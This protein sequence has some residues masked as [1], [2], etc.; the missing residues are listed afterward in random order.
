MV[1][2]LTKRLLCSLPAS[3][4]DLRAMRELLLGDNYLLVSSSGFS[5]PGCT[6]KRSLLRPLQLGTMS[7]CM[8][9]PQFT[10]V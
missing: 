7:A 1:A 6:H 9:R 3:Y 2:T 8:F 10:R 4:R 5:F